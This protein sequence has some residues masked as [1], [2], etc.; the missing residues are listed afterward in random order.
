MPALALY[1]S[2]LI[3]EFAK[4]GSEEWVNNN[5]II[6]KQIKVIR[7]IE[8]IQG[9]SLFRYDYLLETTNQNLI[10]EQ[11]NLRNLTKKIN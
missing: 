1:K 8:K 7:N 11:E 2:G 5:D 9:F 6:S 4:T 10:I 3:D